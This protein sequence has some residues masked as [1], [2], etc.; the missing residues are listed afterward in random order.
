ME[1][2]VYYLKMPFLGLGSRNLKIADAEGITIAK[3]VKHTKLFE[4]M[5]LFK[6]GPVKEILYQ[7]AIPE[8][9]GDKPAYQITG[10]EGQLYGSVDRNLTKQG[11]NSAEWLI[12]DQ[13]GAIVARAVPTGKTGYNIISEKG[14]I[15]GMIKKQRGISRRFLCEYQPEAVTLM[16]GALMLSA[17]ALLLLLD[18]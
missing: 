14:N 18:K 11:T 1:N 9:L 13:G 4:E 8:Q 17:P 6:T 5:T 15:M 16:N 3:A 10:G 12:H 2:T 7:A